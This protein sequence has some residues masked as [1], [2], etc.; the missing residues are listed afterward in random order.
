MKVRMKENLIVRYQI[1]PEF[2]Y[3]KF[4]GYMLSVPHNEMIALKEQ[5]GWLE[6]FKLKEFLK[7]IEGKEVEL[8]FKENDAFEKNDNNY[9]LPESLWF[10][11]EE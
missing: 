7:S 11:I 10:I 5:C 3:R 1:C 2:N 6:Y 8:V 4:H 9:W